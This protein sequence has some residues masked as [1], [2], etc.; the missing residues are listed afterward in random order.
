MPTYVFEC[1]DTNQLFELEMSI[2]KYEERKEDI[3]S[4]FTDSENVRRIISA[5]MI[6]FKGE[7]WTPK[8]YAD[9]TGKLKERTQEAKSETKSRGRE[10]V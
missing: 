6:Q 2:K 4:P 7:G 5:P 1:L 9:S 10:K 3:R 8:F